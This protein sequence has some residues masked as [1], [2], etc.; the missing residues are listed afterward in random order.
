MIDREQISDILKKC[1]SIESS[2]KW[3]KDNPSKGQCSVTALVIQN[4]FAGE[5]LKT[6]VNGQWHFYNRI[7]DQIL[8]F[9][10]SQFGEPIQYQN[11]AISVE[12]AS[13]DTTEKQYEHL[14]EQ[15]TRLISSQK[16]T[17]NI[18]G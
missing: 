16:K 9:T 4:T 2:S 8:D 12:E 5:I 15:F 3:E 14:K 13:K 7:D 1:W 18:N 17:N 11:I 10:S 6:R